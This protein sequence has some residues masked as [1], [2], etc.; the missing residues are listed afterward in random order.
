MHYAMHFCNY[1]KPFSNHAILHF[2]IGTP[3]LHKPCHHACSR[4]SA[5]LAFTTVDPHFNIYDNTSISNE[6][7]RYS[8]QFPDPPS[9]FLHLFLVGTHAKLLGR[10]C[11]SGFHRMWQVLTPRRAG[12]LNCFKY[13]PNIQQGVDA[14]EL[15]KRARNARGSNGTS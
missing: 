3:A 8:T 9:T 14:L 7:V 10:T 2:A 1:S 6:L 13:E 15:L 11:E 5:Q 12:G 4:N